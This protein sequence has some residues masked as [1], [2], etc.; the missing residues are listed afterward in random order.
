MWGIILPQRTGDG[1]SIRWDAG[2]HSL[3]IRP[4]IDLCSSLGYLSPDHSA[5]PDST[6]LNCTQLTQ[7]NSVQPSQSCFCLWR[8]DLQTESTVVHA[9]CRVEFS[10]VE[11]CRYKHPFRTQLNWDR[12]VFCQSRQSEQ[13]RNFYNQ[14]SWVESG[15]AVWSRE[16]LVLTQFPVVNQ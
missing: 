8:H 7:M 12:P 5:G 16:K 14:L 9:R 11:L 15:R 6:Q 1:K 3:R 10:W 13:V 2:G 4:G